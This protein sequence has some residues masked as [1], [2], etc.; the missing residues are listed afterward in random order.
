VLNSGLRSLALAILSFCALL[1][2][3]Q[4]QPPA[5]V[6]SPEVQ[7]DNRVIFRFRDPNAQT[8]EVQLEGRTA[9]IPMQKDDAGVWSVTTDALEPDFYG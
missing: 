3:A 6:A 2:L 9:H 8:V 7:S 1:V 5:P 4:Q